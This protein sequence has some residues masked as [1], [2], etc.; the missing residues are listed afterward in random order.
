MRPRAIRPLAFAERP[1]SGDPAGLLILHHGRGADEHQ[2]LPLAHRLDP[3]RRLHVVTPRGPLDRR[4]GRG[5]EWYQ[6]RRVGYPGRATFRHGVEALARF[7][8]ATWERTGIGPADTVLGG[9]SQGAA[10]SYALGLSGARPAPAGVLAFSG[11]IPTVAGAQPD[12]SSRRDVG[13]FIAH[14]RRDPAVDVAFAH[15]ARELLRAAGLDVEYHEGDGG[16][17]MDPAHAHAARDWLQARLS[18]PRARPAPTP[19]DR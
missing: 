10:M 7:H 19:P 17:V 13:A 15:R 3:T 12:L 9:F 2:L 1:A 4:G 5:Y 14:G 8:D 16:H 11:P 6:A 18:A